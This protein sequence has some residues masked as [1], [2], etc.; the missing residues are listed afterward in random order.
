M[1][2]NVHQPATMWN[3]ACQGAAEGALVW[4]VYWWVEAFLLHIVPWFREPIY[5]YVPPNAGFSAVLLILYIA[6]GLLTGAISG[7]ALG[8]WAERH[9]SNRSAAAILRTIVTLSL[10]LLAAIGSV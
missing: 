1:D 6:A 2:H 5:Q 9:P 10:F 4:M 8:A 7:A 3:F